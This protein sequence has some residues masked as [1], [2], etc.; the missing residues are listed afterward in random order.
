[1]EPTAPENSR[2]QRRDFTAADWLLI[3]ANVLTIASLL[4]LQHSLTRA[5]GH[6]VRDWGM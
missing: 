3:I 6:A 4:W 1:M 5:V 2:M